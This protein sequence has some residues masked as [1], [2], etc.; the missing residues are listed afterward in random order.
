MPFETSFQVLEVFVNHNSKKCCC[1]A[2]N[3]LQHVN[4]AQAKYVN[5]EKEK[6]GTTH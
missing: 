5:F 3:I 1:P 2:C 4:I 6:K